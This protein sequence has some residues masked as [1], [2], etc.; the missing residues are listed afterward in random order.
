MLAFSRNDMK[1]WNLKFLAFEKRKITIN[2]DSNVFA[3][4]VSNNFGNMQQNNFN[5]QILLTL[6]LVLLTGLPLALSQCPRGSTVLN[7]YRCSSN[8]QCQNISPNYFCNSGVCCSIRSDTVSTV[9]YGGYCT[10]SEQCN[11]VGA[12]CISHICQCAPDSHY[13]G[14]SCVSTLI[15]CPSNQILISGKCY[16]KVSYGFLCS[17]TQQC[18]Y[19]GAFCTDG[20][21][22][23]QKNY[24]FDGSK[25]IS[26]F[27]RCTENQVSIDGYCYAVSG[28][29]QS[30]AYSQ[31][32]IDQ[33]YRSL[34]C[35]NGYCVIIL[36][37]ESMLMN[38]LQYSATCKDEH[39]KVEYV[40]GTIKNCLY[41]PCTVGYFCEY[42]K[43]H[44][45]GQYIC[46]GTNA[47]DIYGKVKVYPGTNNP[48][49]C[50]SLSSCTFVDTPNCVMSYRYGHKVCCST[51]N[52]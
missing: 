11:S 26:R 32:C 46:C 21:C 42:N 39:A 41:T 50:T 24:T 27:Q 30:C 4:T 8:I 45:D 35:I 36:N 52:C 23:C 49:L 47:N 18:G 51:M 15:F 17:Y 12:V 2:V 9:S 29:G 10:K 3:R 16:R 43:Y 25:C 33:W 22:R 20:I 6:S 40:N 14:N 7:G 48:L 5:M 31:Q 1:I 37:D 13:N 44:N 34:Q 38:P 28:L 19:I